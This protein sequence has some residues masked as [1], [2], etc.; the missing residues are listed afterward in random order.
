[1]KA[2]HMSW[3]Q[4]LL[5]L[6]GFGVVIGALIVAGAVPS[7]ALQTVIQ[8][9]LTTP[10]GWRDILRETTPLLL[11]GCSVFLALKAGLFNIGADGQFVVGAMAS[12]A[13]AL[14]NFGPLTIPLAIV[15]GTLAGGLWALPVGLIKA[16]R[17]G[18]EVITT[19]MLNNIAFFLSVFLVKGVLK[20]PESQSPTTAYIA[21]A[22][23]LPNLVQN[24]PFRLNIALLFAIAVA[25]ALWWYLKRTVGGY[26]LNATGAN[27]KAAKFA[28]IQIEKVIVRS[29]T[30]SG[31]IAGL[32]GALQVLAYENRFYS[33]FSP[34]YGFDALGVALLAG[35]SPLALLGSGLLFGIIGK[36][37]TVLSLTGVPKGLSFILLGI[38]VIVF[39]SFRY[40]KEPSHD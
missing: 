25:L 31:A 30:T 17:G 27:S 32:A 1:M 24:G 4:I 13:V 22:A 12:V 5:A 8:K 23:K 15:V 10:A 28:G 29:M 6:A 38:L 16:Y 19:I 36:S 20:D 35:G 26:E 18:H 7:D 39:A 40:R 34:G 37:T 21:E 2:F 9:A 33:G 14:Q 3:K 11:L